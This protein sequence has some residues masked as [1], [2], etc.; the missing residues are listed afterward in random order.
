M[1]TNQ[2]RIPGDGGEDWRGEEGVGS[3]EFQCDFLIQLGN[4][5]KSCFSPPCPS[6]HPLSVISS[7][8]RTVTEEE[9]KAENYSCSAPRKL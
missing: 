3:E 1:S 8:S 7:L 2:P 5:R 4:E 9:E 6:L